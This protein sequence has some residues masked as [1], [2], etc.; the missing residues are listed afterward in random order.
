MNRRFLGAG[1]ILSIATWMILNIIALT[2]ITRYSTTY[3]LAIDEW[4]HIIPR[5][6]LWERQQL[7]FTELISVPPNAPIDLHMYSFLLIL[8]NLIWFDWSMRVDGI[9]NYLIASINALVVVYLLA[10]VWNRHWA[11]L[12][13]PILCIM[14]SIQQRYN[15]LVGV[16][17]SLFVSIFFTVLA[18]MILFHAP[19]KTTRS[20]LITL[21]ILFLGTFSSYVG[22]FSWVILTP[23]V[24][25]VG[26]RKWQPL[27]LWSGVG[28][29]T[30]WLLLQV[31][32]YSLDTN[33]EFYFADTTTSLLGSL[34][35]YFW[36]FLA[37]LGGLFTSSPQS[38]LLLRAF[39][40]AVMGVVLLVWNGLQLLRA[41]ENYPLLQVCAFL[42]GYSMLYGAAAAFGRADQFG[43]QQGLANHYIAFSA[44]FWCGVV[45]LI[46]KNSL[47]KWRASQKAPQA[48]LLVNGL[49]LLL[50]V[51]YYALAG[52]ESFQV[53][54][55]HRPFVRASEQCF[56]QLAD[57]ASDPRH[58]CFVVG[59]FVP[60]DD[61][62]E[63]A[64]FGLSGFSEGR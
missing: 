16:H 55:A 2:Y 14:L 42:I 53:G 46:L 35:N 7:T 28:I 17:K 61:I 26:Y 45:A 23:F 12:G 64:Q 41:R 8:P 18:G 32:G 27:L 51:Y 44:L 11:W 10:K 60:A 48:I 59:G 30:A 13:V 9:I 43:V 39:L 47:D 22:W 24:W 21:L 62:R 33:T 20:L 15:F 3:P 31:P 37:Y 57:P 29:G 4:I 56:V 54:E 36:F 5:V 63:F 25:V 19:N 6:V 49:F 34:G 52:V 40:M 1:V 58:A 38:G 50:A